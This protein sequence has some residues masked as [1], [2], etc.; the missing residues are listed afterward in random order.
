MKLNYMDPVTLTSSSNVVK[1]CNC[2]C[3][4]SLS[5]ESPR[6]WLRSV[7]RKYDQFESDSRPTV[8][9]LDF[10]S[11]ARVLIENEC[12]LLREIVSSQQQAIQDLYAELEEERNASSTAAN[13]AMSM[14]LRLQREKAEIQMEARQFKRF[15][16]E[17]TLHD[18]EEVLAL[19]DL[20]YKREQTI[21]SLTC[22]VQAYKYRMMSYGLTEAEADGLNQS[23]E[24]SDFQYEIPIY[25]YPPLK[26]NVHEAY[27]VAD[28]ENDDTDIEKYAFGETPR[29]RLRNLEN[30]ISQM[31]RSPSYSQLDKDFTGKNILE[32]V[33]VGHSPR[34]SRHS[35]KYSNDSTPVVGMGRETGPELLMDSP[36]RNGSFRKMDYVS[37][38]EEYA[39]LKKVDNT[40]EA[41]DDMSDRVYTID[42]IHSG[43]PHNGFTESK[44]GA[45]VYDKFATPLR[46]SL[47]HTEFEDPYVKKLCMRLQALEADRESLRQAMISMRTDK[48]QLVL[49]K[50]IAQH[51][52]KDV[53]PQ[54]RMIVKK[55]SVIGSFSFLSVFKWVTA[56]VLWRKRARRSKFV[57]GLPAGSGGLLMLLDKGP[58]RMS[59]GSNSILRT[60]RLKNPKLVLLESCSNLSDLK[61]LHAHMIRTHLFFDV[62]VASRLV[63]FCI[64]TSLLS[65]VIRV[66]SQIQNPD[67]F[68]FNALPRGCSGSENPANSFN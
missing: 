52:C 40:S 8:P 61:I 32:K 59:G 31:E 41:G 42:S 29:N 56:F 51:L 62:F 60:L 45:G 24:E 35:R 34:R 13:E 36:K 39:N 2:G 57:F 67:L 58:R 33:V 9:G 30:R 23:M 20:L 43:A 48:A 38:P 49:L 46:D 53:S 15:T 11:V 64:E 19:E 37:H 68:I 1:C 10:T 25:D 66:F 4:C 14:I 6:T 27:A 44:A 28:A 50:E 54:G 47:N 65:Y 12:A 22:E 16:E 26:C 18:Q 21:Q 55:P 5:A 7:K 3:S 17:K 63:A